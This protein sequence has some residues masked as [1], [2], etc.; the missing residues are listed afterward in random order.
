MQGL[1]KIIAKLFLQAKFKSDRILVSGD[2]NDA[3]SKL[4]IL[5]AKQITNNKD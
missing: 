5:R 3:F 1:R 2:F 4:H